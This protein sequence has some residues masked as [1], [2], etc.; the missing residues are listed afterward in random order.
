MRVDIYTKEDCIWCTKAKELLSEKQIS[1]KEHKLNVDYTREELREMI[2]ANFRL[3]VP[4][5]YVNGRRVG[6][7]EDLVQFFEQNNAEN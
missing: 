2:G 6:G 1:Y 7:Y 4:Q 5:I 3:T